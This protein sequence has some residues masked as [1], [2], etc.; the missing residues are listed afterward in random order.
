MQ[1]EKYFKYS[2]LLLTLQFSSLFPSADQRKETVKNLSQEE[3][4][5]PKSG[6]IHLLQGKI[7]DGRYYAPQGVFSCQA[8]DLGEGKYI[9]Q[10]ALLDQVAC[11]GFYNHMADHKKAEIFLFPGLEKK[12]SDEKDLKRAFQSFGVGILKSVDQAQGVEILT[13]EML[14]GGMFFALVSVQKI[15]FLK[16]PNGQ[17]MPVTRGYLVFQHKDK[18][19]LLSNQLVTL[20]G[21]KHEPMKHMKWL[22][23]EILA[24][25]KTFEFGAIPESVLE[26]IKNK[27]SE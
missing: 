4:F 25:Q 1:I 13:E 7:S 16:Y 22:K 26:K 3:C 17:P 9:A 2:F 27:A 24:F 18:L 8:C 11:V 20:S 23:R 5:C 12:T 19:A 10:D 14:D 6:K 15:S 21:Q